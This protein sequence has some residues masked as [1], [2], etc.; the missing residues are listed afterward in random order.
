MATVAS[1]SEY[2]AMRGWSP[3][4]VTKLLKAG[5]L[6]T[7]PDGKKIMVEASDE[8]I[9]ATADPAKEGVRRR[10]AEQKAEQ[11]VHQHTRATAPA[12]DPADA[13]DPAGDGYYDFQAARAKRETHLAKLAE[14]EEQLKLGKLLQADRVT[15][16]LTDNAAAMRAALERLPDR[17][18]P[19]LAAESDQDAVYALL[20]AEIGNLI[21]ELR[22][23]AMALPDALSETR[24]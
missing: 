1:K 5:R 17:L 20:E 14:L 10:W 12:D 11:D 9:Q 16:A 3:A 13:A 21:D 7:T 2:A 24:Q 6:V 19:V 4:N 18:A 23:V 22:R 15:K 8:R